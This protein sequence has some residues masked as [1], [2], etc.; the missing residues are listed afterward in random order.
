[1]PVILVLCRF[2]VISLL[3]RLFL[4]VDVGLSLQRYPVYPRSVCC[5]MY[6]LF[7]L[8]FGCLQTS[9]CNLDT[10]PVASSESSFLCSRRRPLC[11]YSVAPVLLSSIWSYFSKSLHVLLRHVS[12]HFGCPA[13][14][15]H[16]YPCAACCAMYGSVPPCGQCVQHTGRW[17]RQALRCIIRRLY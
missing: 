1:M 6:L 8:S 2:T 5:A 11:P 10:Q 4:F 14:Y 9:A 7:S 3:Q 13:K 15:R 12:L 17:R 16:V